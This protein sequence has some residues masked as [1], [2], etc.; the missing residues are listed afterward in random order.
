MNMLYKYPSITNDKVKAD[1]LIGEEYK[2]K[3]FD[4]IITEE[5]KQGFYST[6]QVAY[7]ESNQE[8]K[9]SREDLLLKAKELG[10]EFAKNIKN[11]DLILL[12]DNALSE[13]EDEE[14]NQE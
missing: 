2:I 1:V 4:Y 14:S 9:Q 10:L 12:I 3:E 6:V 7:E 5:I 13:L 8:P 11:K